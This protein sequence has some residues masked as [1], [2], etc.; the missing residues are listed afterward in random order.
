MI[1]ADWKNWFGWGFC[2][3]KFA[4]HAKFCRPK[5]QKDRK[6]ERKKERKKDRFEKQKSN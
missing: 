2:T 6:K 4:W 1:I 3:K 5:G